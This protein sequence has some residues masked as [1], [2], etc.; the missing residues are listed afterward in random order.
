MSANSELLMVATTENAT[1]PASTK[2]RLM[3]FATSSETDFA[4]RSE[5]PAAKVGRPPKHTDKAARQADFRA[6]NAIVSWRLDPA[7]V[8]KIKEI[9]LATD[10]SANELASQMLKFALAN[11]DWRSFPMFGR[12]LPHAS[13]KERR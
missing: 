11:R 7:T 3:N 12:P 9:A 10:L 8:D 4:T 2:L 5:I 1:P 13:K 6:R